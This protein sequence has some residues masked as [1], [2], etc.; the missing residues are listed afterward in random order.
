MRR[1]R[2]AAPQRRARLPSETP[3]QRA[4]QRSSG[5]QKRL[6]AR[7]SPRVPPQRRAARQPVTRLATP[8]PR[9]TPR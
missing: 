8:Q 2:S 4:A 5:E 1:A 6:L 3:F 9:A 7:V